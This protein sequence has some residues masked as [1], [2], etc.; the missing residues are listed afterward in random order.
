MSRFINKYKRGIAFFFLLNFVVDVFFPTASWALTSGPSQPEVQ[1]F[2]PVNVSDMVDPGTGDF[3]YNMP[4]MDIDGYP[5][6]LSYRSGSGMDQ[7]SGIVGLGWNLNV[8]SISRGMR[9]I[10]DD[11]NGEIIKKKF[12]VKD[13]ISYG[14]TI[15]VGGELFGTDVINA[16][17]SQTITYNTYAGY[18]FTQKIGFSISLGNASVGLGVASG[19]DGLTISPNISLSTQSDEKDGNSVSGSV[20]LGTSF[21]S[22]SGMKELSLGVGVS[23]SHKG[24]NKNN[25]NSKAKRAE[26]NKESGGSASLASNGSS[27]MFGSPTWVPQITMPMHTF[28]VA[29]S[30]K[31]GGTLFGVDVSADIAGNYSKQRLATK[32]VDI[33]S[34]GYLNLQ[35]GQGADVAMLDFNREKDGS[36]SEATTNLPVPNLTYDNYSVMGQG[37]GGSFRPFRSD[38]GYVYDSRASNTSESANLGVEVDLGNTAHVGVDFVVTTVDGTSGKWS[39]ENS[40]LSAIGFSG[41]GHTG[42]EPAYFKEMGEMNVDDDQLYN[43]IKQEKAVRFLLDDKGSSVGLDKKLIDENSSIFSVSTYNKRTKRTKRNQLFS[44]LTVAEYKDFG[45]QKSLYTS[46][47]ARFAGPNLV[48]GHHIG[49]IT[50]TKTDGTRYVYGLPV[51]NTYQKEATFNISGFAGSAFTQSNNMIKYN[52]GSDDTENNSKGT[53]N[54]FTSVETPAYAY[55]YMLTAVL[56]SDY[57][58]KT[59]DGPTPDDLGTYTLFNYTKTASGYKWRTPH[60]NPLN[61]GSDCANFDEGILTSKTDNKASYV[62]GEKDIY[63]IT[64]IETKNHIAL[65]DYSPR[66]DAYGV[67][68]DAGGLSTAI[69]QQKLDLIT[70]YSMPDYKLKLANPLYNPFVIKQVHFSYDY[71]LCANVYNNSGA[72]QIVNGN[73]INLN[74]GKLTLKEVYFT[75]G[76]SNKGKLSPYKFTYNNTVASSIVNYNPGATDRWGNYKPISPILPNSKFPYTEQNQTLEDEYVSLWNLK[77]IQLPSGGLI[78]IE[79]ESDDYAY[80]QNK[81]AGEMFKIEGFTNPSNP[82]AAAALTSFSGDLFNTVGLPNDYLYFKLKTPVTSGYTSFVNDYLSGIDKLYFRALIRVNCGSNNDVFPVIPTAGHTGYEYIHGYVDFDASNSGV[83]TNGLYGFIKIKTVR[84]DKL[85]PQ[86][87]HPFSKASWQFARTT[88][89]KDAYSCSG[90]ADP[91]SGASDIEG[92]LKAI[93]D[94]DFMKNTIQFFQGANGA[95]KAL[96]YGKN[97]DLQ[98]SWIRLSNPDFHKLGGGLRVKELTIRDKWNDMLS[99]NPVLANQAFQY[100]QKYEYETEENGKIISSGVAAYEPS[101]GADENPFRHPIFM[102]MH[103]EEA[104]LAPDNNMYLEAPMGESFF[105]APTVN[106]SRVTIKNL[107][108]GAGK[109]VNEYYTAKDFPTYVHEL[110]MDALRKKPD[111]IFS[112]FSFS[113]YDKF[114]GSQGYSIELNDMHGKPKAVHIYEEGA[115]APTTSTKYLYKSSGDK[116]INNVRTVSK[117]GSLQDSRIGVD[118]DFYADFREN[119]TTTEAI[120]IQGN[121][122]FMFVGVYPLVVPPILPTYHKEEIQLRT[123]VTNK[124]IYKFGILDKVETIQNGNIS[125]T[126]NLLWD[127]ETGQVL[128]T[129]TTTEFKDPIYNTTY[130]SHWAYEGTAGGYKDFGLV[131]NNPASIVNTAGQ[132]TNATYKSMLQPGDELALYPSSGAPVKGWIDKVGN[133]YY[134]ITGTAGTVLT[135]S[136][137]GSYS[138]LKV[139]RSGRRNLQDMKVAA[140]S[141]FTNPLNGNPTFWPTMNENYGILNASSVEMGTKWSTYCGCGLT[142]SAQYNPYLEGVKGNWRKIKDY[143]YLS[144]RKQEKLNGNSNIRVDGTFDKFAPFYTPNAGNDWTVNSTNWRWVSEVTKYSP[145]GPELENKDALNRYSSAQYGYVQSLPVA[146]SSNSR[147]KQS[148]FEGFEYSDLKH[149]PDDHLGFNSYET[150]TYL[151]VVGTNPKVQTYSHTGKRSIKIA[152]GS[153]TPVVITKQLN[154]CP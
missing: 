65:L 139:I 28:A 96:N 52:P 129:S 83:T 18:G 148:A 35:N 56:S 87:E 89:P 48:N 70:L 4:L 102:E 21:N 75:Y 66:H 76:K 151:P 132:I 120:G 134:I 1:E 85:F 6:N 106:Y 12:N 55:G 79:L 30:F 63:N 16:N 13:N 94:A 41:G 123:A 137:L 92:I 31:I 50:T 107:V 116:L 78:D 80:V 119:N 140:V 99:N 25:S 114:T 33:P 74:K 64:S 88:T 9:G 153:T 145:V 19:A 44:Y 135:S 10:P 95:L 27:I 5:I 143:T 109:T 54:F 53:D 67:L 34:F 72:V 121:L 46:D 20:S 125:A 68:G 47:V 90:N 43:Q 24:D 154:N 82:T 147:F 100:G 60:S 81:R 49:E 62:Y 98:R 91:A 42:Y 36:F 110:G 3:S 93:A 14:V 15:G 127:G 118:Y 126:E 11:F 84:Q 57:V 26:G 130:P 69:G 141:S 138:K 112:L 51:Y 58:D 133:D 104:L 105:P 86:Q 77:T 59:N 71:E 22:R 113:V 97:V 131:V 115:L 39:D 17:Y 146:V 37:V 23:M 45:V 111:P 2:Q 144:V 101:F 124:V 29:T 73:N 32:H 61:G 152:G 8:G 103:K 136:A 122:Y 149:C 38:I 7:E 40:A 108:A 117:S 128:L 142:A 150:N